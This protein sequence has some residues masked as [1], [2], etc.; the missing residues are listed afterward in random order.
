MNNLGELNLDWT[1]LPSGQ[2][3]RTHVQKQLDHI[4]WNRFGY[5]LLSIGPFAPGLDYQSSPVRLHCSVGIHRG[6]IRAK[7]ENLPI[8]SDSMDVVVLPLALDFCSNPHALLREVQRVITGD[9]HV[10][11]MGLNPW[12]LWGVRR[13]VG[14]R[15]HPLWQSRFLAMQ[16]VLD[17][18]QLLG[19][20]VGEQSHFFYQPPLKTERWQQ[21]WDFI[22]RFG[23]RY[24]PIAGACYTLCAQKREMPVTPLR[25]RKPRLVGLPVGFPSPSRREQAA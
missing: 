24:W 15:D 3:L 11:I 10:I 23:K 8:R 22:E 9:G 13:Y 1:S 4:L 19:F 25:L 7:A 2:L 5:H 6:D 14:R 21:R 16:R 18:L 20:E 12:S 17:W